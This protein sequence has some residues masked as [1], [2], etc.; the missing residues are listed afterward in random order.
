[1]SSVIASTWKSEQS[2]RIA[3][4]PVFLSWFDEVL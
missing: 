2:G 3:A 4:L 1:M